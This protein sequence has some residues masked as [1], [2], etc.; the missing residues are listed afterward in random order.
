MP[1]RIQWYL[2][3]TVNRLAAISTTIYGLNANGCKPIE[4]VKLKC[5]IGELKAKVTSYVI[6]ADMSN[7]L[8]LRRP[9][10]HINLIITSM[11]HQCMKYIDEE[12]IAI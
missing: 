5:H 2:E 12:V 7:N 11:L 6:D 8:L 9:W 1:R 4:K 10:I 3:I